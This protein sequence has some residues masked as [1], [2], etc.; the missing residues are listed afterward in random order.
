MK[1]KTIRNAKQND[2]QC[3]SDNRRLRDVSDNAATISKLSGRVS[4]GVE[5]V[6]GLLCSAAAADAA[7]VSTCCSCSADKPPAMMTVHA[8]NRLPC[9]VVRSATATGATT[10]AAASRRARHMDVHRATHTRTVT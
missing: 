2:S 5:V 7:A 10:A 4:E 3:M 6:P 9:D 8:F 1:I